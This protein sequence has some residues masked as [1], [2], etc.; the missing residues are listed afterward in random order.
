VSDQWARLNVGRTPDTCGPT[1]TGP[2]YLPKWVKNVPRVR[3]DRSAGW[4]FLLFVSVRTRSDRR[5][6]F[7]PPA[8]DALRASPAGRP[9]RTPRVRFCPTGQ[10][11]QKNSTQRADPNVSGG[12]THPS[13]AQIWGSDGSARTRA[14]RA[15]V[16]PWSTCHRPASIRLLQR[17]ASARVSASRR[18][19]SERWTPGHWPL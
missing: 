12:R 10:R 9:K 11:G 1:Q 4:A 19:E 6:S 8:G 7:G 16:L 3:L 17:D 15:R 14:D 5:W 2:K 18:L 13:A